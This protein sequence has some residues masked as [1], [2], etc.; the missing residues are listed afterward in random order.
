MQT[1]AKVSRRNNGNSCSG[2]KRV[3]AVTIAQTV[4]ASAGVSAVTDMN[5]YRCIT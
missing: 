2:S 1:W 3:G 4:I 5:I